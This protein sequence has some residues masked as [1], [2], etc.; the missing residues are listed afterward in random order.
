MTQENMNQIVAK[1]LSDAMARCQQQGVD[2]NALRTGL[3]TITIANFVNRTGMNNAINLFEALPAQ[4]RSGIFDKFINPAVE[5]G[6]SGKTVRTAP[7][8]SPQQQPMPQ[9]PVAPAHATPLS[10][11]QLSQEQIGSE[12]VQRR[13]LL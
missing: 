7:P 6:R 9:T 5:A 4:M 10:A 3:L 8:A 13:K 12:K 2:E 1:E 11:F